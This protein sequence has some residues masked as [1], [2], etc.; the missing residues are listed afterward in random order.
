M[1]LNGISNNLL[2]IG[3][4]LVSLCCLYLLFSNFSK[5]R[6]IEEM[7]RKVEDLKNIFF[8]QQKHN[9]ESFAKMIHLIQHQSTALSP[10]TY[11]DSPILE[12]SSQQLK[13]VTITNDNENQLPTNIIINKEQSNDQLPDALAKS[14]VSRIPN[15]QKEFDQ[16]ETK[17]VNIDLEELND[18]DEPIENDDTQ[19]IAN[20][21][22]ID[23]MVQLD[24]EEIENNENNDNDLEEHIKNGI[25]ATSA[26]IEI[27]DD[28]IS[29]STDPI[30]N[31]DDIMLNETNIDDM[32]DITNN[33]LELDLDIE[34]MLP[35]ATQR[36]ITL[37][38]T[39]HHLMGHL[40]ESTPAT[41]ESS[42]Q[43]ENT[44]TKTIIIDADNTL[45]NIIIS[46]TQ[47]DENTKKIIITGKGN[48]SNIEAVLDDNLDDIDDLDKLLSGNTDEPKPDENF[49]KT[50]DLT[51]M[52]IKQLKE[53]AKTHKLKSTGTKNE[54]ITAL[55]KVISN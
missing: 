33:D 11:P 50:H 17:E 48:S 18:L 26:K 29:I 52:S 43:T 28:N 35:I 46:D 55:S 42:I 4:V 20:L 44:L 21:D 30:A 8:N 10:V 39:D 36:V 31:L 49:K 3:F 45:D 16:T 9:D 1:D 22:D 6:E 54:L 25:F 13:T 24:D 47:T 38:N 19:D 41:N 53:L 34:E 15:Q 23:N 7:K 37:N 12:P 27:F 40:E 32:E 51:S 14:D 5:T 2:L